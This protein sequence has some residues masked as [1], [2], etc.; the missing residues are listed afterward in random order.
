[1]VRSLDSIVGT[2]FPGSLHHIIKARFPVI[3]GL[4]C[5][6]C[7]YINCTMILHP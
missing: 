7:M 3:H 2:G 5:H 4:H 6:T 1:M